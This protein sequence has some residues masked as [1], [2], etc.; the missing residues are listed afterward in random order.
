M[1]SLWLCLLRLFT[2]KSLVAV[3]HCDGWATL[4]EAKFLPVAELEQNPHD[5]CVQMVGSSILNRAIDRHRQP[6]K[7]S[8]TGN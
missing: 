2:Y 4:V 3:A 6:L 1:H 5:L 7:Q 8:P